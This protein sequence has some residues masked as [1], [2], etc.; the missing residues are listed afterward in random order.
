[1]RLKHRDDDTLS[2]DAALSLTLR[3]AAPTIACG[4]LLIVLIAV[5]IRRTE[6][7]SGQYISNGVPPLPAFAVLLI[8][9]LL[10]PVLQRYLPRLAPSRAQ[11]LLL[12]SMLTVAVILSGLYHVRAFLPHLVALQYWSKNSATA[13]FGDYAQYLPKWYAPHDKQAIKDYYEGT[14]PNGRIPWPVWL[15]PLGCWSLFFLAM[16]VGVFS[17]MTL[18]RTQWIRNEKLS[19]P[20]LTIPLA[21]T[22]NEGFG[23]GSK[24]TRRALFLAGFGLAALFDLVNILHVLVPSVPAPGFVV[25]IGAPLTQRPWE[26]LKSVRVIFMLE[27]IGIGYF[28]PLDVSFSTWFFYFFAK[29]IAIG[30]SALGYEQPGFPFV[31][32][33]CA[34]GYIAMGF[35]LLWGLRRTF[36]ESL[37]RAFRRGPRDADARTERRA[38]L[39]LFGSILLV[40][41]FCRAAGLSL[42]LGVPFFGVV[43]LFVLVF[44]RM[45]AETGV[46]LTFIFPEGMANEVIVNTFSVP[47]ALHLGGERGFVL[48]S[49]LGW[50]SRF[51]HPEDEAAYQIDAMKLAQEER[52]PLRT[53]FVALL[54]AFL[55]GLWAAE[56]VHLS[57]YYAQGSNLIAS[58]GGIGEYRETL[59]REGYQQMA[60]RL[61]SLPPRNLSQSFA[62][63]GGFCFVFLLTLLRRQWQG[64]PFH[65]L[66]FLMATAYGDNSGNWFAL[67]VAWLCKALILRA[68]GLKAYRGGMPFFL[69]LAIGH[70]LIG[71][72]LWP[73]FSLCLPREAAN[74]YHLIFGE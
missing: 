1:M 5:A 57:A 62:A 65:P 49:T 7:V 68:G 6:M 33:Q 31:Q 59:A 48:L 74:A 11:M 19:F 67:L 51:Q 23:Y 53:L 28:V 25:P 22:S 52:I 73:L 72:V 47:Q 15:L 44:A 3:R 43:G 16:F 64:C 70:L 66:G 50:L 29:L 55:V 35:I 8:L 42:W 10:R 4:L 63:A 56:W 38:W 32:E 26:S 9:S 39:G 40:P 2:S 46:P 20:L 54:L 24:K 18:V 71:G 34:G 36:G 21:L 12:Y 69:G 14:A 13:K 60:S 41:A 58:A 30:G 61:A 17:L 45:R 37:R 27:T